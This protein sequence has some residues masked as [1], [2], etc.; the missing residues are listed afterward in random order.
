MEMSC[1]KF[2]NRRVIGMPQSTHKLCLQKNETKLIMDY[3]QVK[4]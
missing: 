2:E 3:V 4:S 1:K